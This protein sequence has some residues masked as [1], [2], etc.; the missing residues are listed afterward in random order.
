MPVGPT[1]VVGQCVLSRHGV[2]TTEFVSVNHLYSGMPIE[3]T[4]AVWHTQ[5]GA[6]VGDSMAIF[7]SNVSLP[8][9]SATRS[10]SDKPGFE[11]HR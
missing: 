6:R 11:Q 10:M 3:S 8:I 4:G 7:S 9:R 5:Y 2:S 1:K